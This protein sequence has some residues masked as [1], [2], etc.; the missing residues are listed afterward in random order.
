M[1]AAGRADGLVDGESG[2]RHAQSMTFDENSS[3]FITPEPHMLPPRW[4]VGG[5]ELGD[6]LASRD[7]APGGHEAAHPP[8]RLAGE[9]AGVGRPGHEALLGMVA[10]MAYGAASPLA[11]HPFDTVKT[12]CVRGA[13]REWC[14]CVRVRVCACV[15]VRCAPARTWRGVRSGSARRTPPADPPRSCAP[16]RCAGTGE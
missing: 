4:A 6:E 16:N 9:I 2:G 10:G 15:R 12:R 13:S 7:S 11:G 14:V 8:A 5:A 3:Y 1:S